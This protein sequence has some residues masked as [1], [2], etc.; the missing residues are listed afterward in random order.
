MEKEYRV[1]SENNR[2][3]IPLKWNPKKEL[4]VKITLK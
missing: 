4:N 3:T 2:L 1:S